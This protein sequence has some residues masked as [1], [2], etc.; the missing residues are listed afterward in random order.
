MNKVKQTDL[1]TKLLWNFVLRSIKFNA[2]MKFSPAEIFQM[3]YN[4]M[5]RTIETNKIKYL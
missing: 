4:E 1:I 3:F 2:F 5:F